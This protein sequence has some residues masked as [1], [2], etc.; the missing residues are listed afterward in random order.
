MTYVAG[1]RR[2]Q[3]VVIAAGGFKGWTRQ[4]DYLVAFKLPE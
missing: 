3:F 4:G 2:N 1:P